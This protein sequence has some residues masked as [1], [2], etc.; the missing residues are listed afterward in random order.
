MSMSKLSWQTAP[1]ELL[2]KILASLD[3][4][5]DILE[6]M[7]VCENWRRVAYPCL[8]GS[9]SLKS[10]FQATKLARTLKESS[11]GPGALVKELDL[12][13]TCDGSYNEER[14]LIKLIGLCPQL[15]CLNA[16][17][18]EITDTLYPRLLE[19][20]EKGQLQHIRSIPSFWNQEADAL[21]DLHN[22]TAL[23]IKASLTHLQV[24][25][26]TTFSGFRYDP[27][28]PSKKC[29]EVGHTNLLEHLTSFPRLQTIDVDYTAATFLC[30]QD[31]LIDKCAAQ[32]SKVH[33]K[34]SNEGFLKGSPLPRMPQLN[35]EEI[36]QRPY[37]KELLIHADVLTTPDLE[38]IM[39]KF[40]GL[41]KVTVG[42]GYV[43]DEED[44]DWLA[45]NNMLSMEVFARFLQ[46]LISTGDFEVGKLTTPLEIEELLE[47]VAKLGQVKT[48]YFSYCHDVY[49]NGL[50]FSLANKKR[51]LVH[52]YYTEFDVRKDG[53]WEMMLAPLH[54]KF[55]A[56]YT[57]TLRQFAGDLVEQ[58]FLEQV[59][60]E[61]F[62]EDHDVGEA[63]S[64]ILDHYTALKD[65][66]L[67]G[68]K[69][70]FFHA[71]A[72]R[73]CLNILKFCNGT[74]YPGV[75][76]RLSNSLE[77]VNQLIIEGDSMKTVGEE[78]TEI[79][80]EMPCTRFGEIVVADPYEDHDQEL[81]LITIHTSATDIVHYLLSYKELNIFITKDVLESAVS[82]FDADT[83]VFFHIMCVDVEKF[84]TGRVC[85]NIR[86]KQS[87]I[88]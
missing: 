59:V 49:A 21:Q 28:K 34:L 37:V 67:A 65:L 18:R 73:C 50:H 46:F 81:Q 42:G 62:E 70:E 47:T 15:T 63:L 1:R 7:L 61:P 55:M 76:S 56:I 68:V 4:S 12:G 40:T 25:E 79:S 80:V 14:I 85:F 75:L 2:Q 87:C 48:L 6:A 64:Y 19:L 43:H 20:H 26:P 71:N 24:V 9:I 38:Y 82:N 13:S 60:E 69:F 10:T 3:K 72:T 39:H 29:L 17:E 31:S 77:Y 53:A 23:A 8:Y 11:H 66:S 32:T 83:I 84:N 51:E 30:E 5:A 86:T 41:R 58:I 45:A 57:Q 78:D 33:F 35:L 27:R 22:C 52:S 36:K 16:S 88:L 74:I 54:D 44:I